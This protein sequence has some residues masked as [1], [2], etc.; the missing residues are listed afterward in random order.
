MNLLGFWGDIKNMASNK[1]ILSDVAKSLDLNCANKSCVVHGVYRKYNLLIKGSGFFDNNQHVLISLCVKS[2]N[3]TVS[4]Q[5]FLPKGIVM[6]EGTYR[7][8]IYIPIKGGRKHS[9]ERILDFL[10]HFTTV[11]EMNGFV[12]C[13]EMGCEQ[14]AEI[15]LV[16]GE[17]TFLSRVSADNLRESLMQR[18]MSDSLKKENFVLGLAGALGGALIASIVV[19]LVARIGYVASVSSALLGIGLV[20][21][22]K[23]KGVRLSAISA[24]VCILLSIV[25]SYLT[26]RLDMAV[27][28]DKATGIGLA[29]AFDCTKEIMQNS[30]A[31]ITYYRNLALM[32]GAGIIGTIVAVV[33]ELTSQKK[34]FEIKELS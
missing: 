9:V 23:W 27:S 10:N 17:Y 34:E 21:G 7:R 28:I 20:F 15:Y 2:R 5:A 29:E 18:K 6:R 24:V 26:F 16:K 11:L 22:Y 31:M 8:N 19:F 12:N 1:K 33:Y 14:N 32:A 30:D 25:F 3:S 4:L 13:D